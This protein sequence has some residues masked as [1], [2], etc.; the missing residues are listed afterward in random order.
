MASSIANVKAVLQLLDAI[1]CFRDLSLLE[2]N[3]RDILST[4]LIS[5][6]KQQRTY[7]KQRGKINW[8]KEGDAGT[9]YFHFHATITHRK[10]TIA[11]VQAND[12]SVLTQHEE[13]ANH[14]W[15]AFK[16]RIGKSEFS[17]M[18]FNL[19]NLLNNTE[20]LRGLETPFDKIEIDQVIAELPN[21]KSLG[22]DGFNNEFLKGCWPLIAD[23]FYRFCH[24]FCNN[25]I[26]LRCLN[27]SY[28]T[29]IP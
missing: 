1:E 13:K 2:W 25:N 20:D 19:N 10:N 18:L 4:K 26:C 12:G 27:S 28:I 11:S 17:G 9:R 21:N 22:P 3:F 24:D 29:L 5:L 23:D 14:F 16:E 8:V 15:E 7:W 6:L